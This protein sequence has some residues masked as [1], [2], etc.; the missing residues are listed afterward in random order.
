MR[1]AR[2]VEYSERKVVLHMQVTDLRLNISFI[3]PYQPRQRFMPLLA[4]SI[5]AQ[6]FKLFSHLRDG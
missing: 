2:G 4:A 6:T 1:Y 3:Y 5:L